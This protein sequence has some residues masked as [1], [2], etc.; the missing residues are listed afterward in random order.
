MSRTIYINIIIKISYYD[1]LDNSK[2]N[3]KEKGKKMLNTILKCH[4]AGPHA[5][6]HEVSAK[7][8]CF[9]LQMGMI[10]LGS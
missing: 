8:F 7:S 5:L 4:M 9:N 3:L 6:S 2:K 10:K 1:L